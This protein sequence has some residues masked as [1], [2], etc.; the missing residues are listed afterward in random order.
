MDLEKLFCVAVPPA[1]N[2]SLDASRPH[3]FGR[4]LLSTSFFECHWTPMKICFILQDSELPGVGHGSF[5]AEAEVGG[6]SGAVPSMFAPSPFERAGLTGYDSDDEGENDGRECAPTASA[7]D[8]SGYDDCS[9]TD[10]ETR[11]RPLTRSCSHYSPPR[12]GEHVFPVAPAT[13]TCLLSFE[14]YLVEVT[15][16]LS[17]QFSRNEL[18][19]QRHL[20]G[21]T[22]SCCN[23]GC[24]DGALVFI[25][26]C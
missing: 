24:N 19:V 4:K 22:N 12:R 3:H 5:S 25:P 17:F 8:L 21:G 26:P 6:G 20:N 7:E 18:V 2:K 15:W 11:R 10:A 1:D 16:W 14:G 9:T 13:R 23:S